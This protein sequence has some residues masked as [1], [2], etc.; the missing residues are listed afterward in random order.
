MG[1]ELAYRRAKE[2]LKEADLFLVCQRS[3]AFLI[4]DNAISIPFF[5]S[6]R[7]VTV[8]NGEIFKEDG[9]VEEIRASILIL[10]YLVGASG[11][12][13]SGKEI[14]FR[15]LP[16]GINYLGPFT[17]RSIRRLIR[18][19]DND[20]SSLREAALEV[21]AELIEGYGDLAFRIWAF[22]KV[23]VKLIFWKGDEE[24][25]P[26]ANIVF[27]SSITGYLSTEDVVVLSEL[28][29]ERLIGAVGKARG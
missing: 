19:F 23:P 10:H 26:T 12:P 14:D 21:G 15:S 28:M 4:G 17:N 3:G 11:D 8:P 20:I 18:R 5:G 24:F 1:V 27:D 25:D 7:I 9:D 16:G 2:E 22:P 29:V 6:R 13:L